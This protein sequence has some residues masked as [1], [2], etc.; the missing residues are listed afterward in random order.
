M[1]T[2]KIYYTKETEV[3]IIM[4]FDSFIGFQRLSDLVKLPFGG[5]GP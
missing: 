3:N 5:Q 4:S 2:C 1:S